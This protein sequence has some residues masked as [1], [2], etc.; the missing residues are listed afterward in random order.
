MLTLPDIFA[1]FSIPNW[2]HLHFWYRYH[3]QSLHSSNFCFK[4]FILGEFL[5]WFQGGI[6]FNGN[7]RVDEW[8][9]SQHF[10]LYYYITPFRLGLVLW[11]INHCRIFNAKS[12]LYIYIECIIIIITILLYYQHG[13][14]WLS[15]TTPTYRSSLPAGPQGYISY[16]Y[17][18]RGP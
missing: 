13:Y 3:L 2:Q 12:S 9:C 11:H 6:S 10:V 15:L 7:R 17:R 18:I 8:T 14:P 5:C 1:V 16:P 4:I